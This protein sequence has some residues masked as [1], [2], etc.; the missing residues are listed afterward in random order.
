MEE[1]TVCDLSTCQIVQFQTSMYVF[2]DAV[3]PSPLECKNHESSTPERWLL[4]A[5]YDSDMKQ[6]VPPFFC[7]PRH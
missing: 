3:C 7:G 2:E 6:V 1:Y 5:A 4:K